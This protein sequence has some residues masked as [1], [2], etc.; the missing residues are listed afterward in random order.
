MWTTAETHGVRRGRTRGTAGWPSPNA[1]ISA[2]TT[3]GSPRSAPGRIRICDQRISEARYSLGFSRVR[4]ARPKSR[5]AGAFTHSRSLSFNMCHCFR[6]VRGGRCT[7]T[8]ATLLRATL[9]HRTPSY[10]THR[11]R[12]TSECGKQSS[13]RRIRSTLSRSPAYEQCQLTGALLRQPFRLPRQPSS[14]CH[15]HPGKSG[16]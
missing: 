15:S 16:W 3:P 1:G 4:S 5:R 9:S 14:R 12:C 2:R 7:L 13:R 11:S 8:S 10:A 6:W